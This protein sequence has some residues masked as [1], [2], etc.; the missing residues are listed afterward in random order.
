MHKLARSRW[1]EMLST[2]SLSDVNA[3]NLKKYT[4]YSNERIRRGI[5]QG[6]DNIIDAYRNKANISIENLGMQDAFSKGLKGSLIPGEDG[7]SQVQ[8]YL[9]GPHTSYVPSSGN[10]PNVILRNISNRAIQANLTAQPFVAG[11]S[12]AEKDNI[13]SIIRRHEVDEMRHDL[14]K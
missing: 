10:K 3:D 8:K 11:M 2:N 13:S 7:V 5:D 14:M 12:Q 9:L 6:S 4:G 1:K